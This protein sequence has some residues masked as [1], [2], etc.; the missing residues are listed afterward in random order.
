MKQNSYLKKKINQFIL[1]KFSHLK[2]T[3]CE[4]KIIIEDNINNP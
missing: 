1:S 2:L 3:I 4:K